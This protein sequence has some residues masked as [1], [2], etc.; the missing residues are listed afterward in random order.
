MLMCVCMRLQVTECKVGFH[1]HYG[2][3]KKRFS[4]FFRKLLCLALCTI[5]FRKSTTRCFF[6]ECTVILMIRLTILTDIC[7]MPFVYTMNTFLGLLSCFVFHC[8]HVMYQI[9]LHD[10]IAMLDHRE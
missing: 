10:S 7:F 1:E 4:L 6:P 5:R 9:S 3:K 8:I 2:F